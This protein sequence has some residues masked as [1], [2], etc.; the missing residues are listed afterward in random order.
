MRKVAS[1]HCTHYTHQ[2]STLL[3]S[4]FLLKKKKEEE[5]P[6]WKCLLDR[7]EYGKEEVSI[8]WK[9]EESAKCASLLGKRMAKGEKRLTEGMKEESNE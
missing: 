1:H 5:G 9:G 8:D 4:E 2:G 6:R 7:E 3:R